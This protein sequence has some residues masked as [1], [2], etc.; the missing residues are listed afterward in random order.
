MDCDIINDIFIEFQ[1][2]VPSEVSKQI[3]YSDFYIKNV[4]RRPWLDKAGR[5]YSYP[6][7]QRSGLP[8]T[9]LPFEK[10]TEGTA[11]DPNSVEVPDFASTNKTVT[12]YNAAVNTRD[13]CLSELQYDWQIESQL[14]NVVQNLA[15]ATV[16]TW[17]Q[18]LQNR[19]IAECGN[20]IINDAGGFNTRDNTWL[21]VVPTGPLNWNMLDA[22]YQDLRYIA[23][24]DDAC[25][26]DEDSRMVFQLVGEYEQFQQLKMMD[27]NFRDDLRAQRDGNVGPNELLGGLGITSSK[28]Y[29]G[30]KFETVQFAPRYDFINGAWVQRYP[31]KHVN[32]TNGVG[33][34]VD[35]RYKNA[36]YTDV[37]VFVKNVFHHLV[38]RPMNLPRGYNYSIDQDWTGEF[39]WRMLPID[40][41]C[42]PDGN[43]GWWRA[44]FNYGPQSLREDLG[45]TIRVQ[46]CGYG[47][48]AFTCGL[49]SST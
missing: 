22:I 43:K 3:T 26:I 36:G 5:E 48:P 14:A 34:E 7:F 6:V 29:R 25:G 41:Q 20:K 33:L 15:H 37:V 17:S 32:K 24:P 49:P 2:L 12:L 40:K 4:P 27:S 35:E 10:I 13:I 8:E 31:Y 44:V 47:A 18:E 11:C 1:Q 30:W 38:P 46:R 9:F 19:Y 45:Y 21:P 42:N 16:F 28:T 39:R 23:Q